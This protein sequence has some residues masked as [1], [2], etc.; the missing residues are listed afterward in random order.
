MDYYGYDDSGYWFHNGSNYYIPVVKSDIDR[1]FAAKRYIKLAYDERTKAWLDLVASFS[2]SD[3]GEELSKDFSD[4]F[5][6]PLGTP[7]HDLS[8]ESRL[9]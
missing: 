8:L 7:Y 5:R 9:I 6:C 2:D 4:Y 1:F 3:Y